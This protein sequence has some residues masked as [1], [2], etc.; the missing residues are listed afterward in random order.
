MNRLAQQD[1][2]GDVAVQEHNAA[3][4]KFLLMY[5]GKRF[6]HAAHDAEREG[7]EKT[8]NELRTIA[9]HYQRQ[10]ANA[11][12]CELSVMAENENLLTSGYMLVIE[13]YRAAIGLDREPKHDE[14]Q[15]YLSSAI[16]SV[17]YGVDNNPVLDEESAA[18]M[19]TTGECR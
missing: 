18:T 16:S 17:D 12:E 1:Q 10:H 11:G 19:Q 13:A 6:S 8:A 7:D 3:V 4:G 5:H 15:D 2:N 9:A 14:P